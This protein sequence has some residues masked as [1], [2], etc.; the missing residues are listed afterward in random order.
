MCINCIRS[1]S[2]SLLEF[3]CVCNIKS[4]HYNS[5]KQLLCLVD[6]YKKNKIN[7]TT[8][9]NNSTSIE[10]N[11]KEKN[12]Q[13]LKHNNSYYFGICKEPNC[14]NVPVCHECILEPD[15]WGHKISKLSCQDVKTTFIP[16]LHK[17]KNHLQ[18]LIDSVKKRSSHLEKELD[19]CK[20]HLS[21][22]K[23]KIKQSFKEVRQY[24]DEMESDVYEQLESHTK[25]EMNKIKIIQ[26]KLSD[27][28]LKLSKFQEFYQSY[29]SLKSPKEISIVGEEIERKELE[30]PDIETIKFEICKQISNIRNNFLDEKL[31]IN[32]KCDLYSFDKREYTLPLEKIQKIGP[33][34]EIKKYSSFTERSTIPQTLSNISS[35]NQFG[36]SSPQTPL[37]QSSFFGPATTPTSLFGQPTTPTSSLFGQVTTPTTSLF[38]QPTTPTT[39]LFQ[40]TTIPSSTTSSLFGVPSTTTGLFGTT[41]TPTSS[42]FGQVTTP[43]SSLFQSTTIPSSTTSSLFGVPSTTTG[44]FGTTTT[45]TSSFSS[46]NSN[47]FGFAFNEAV[48][49]AITSKEEYQSKSFEELRLL[50]IQKKIKDGLQTH[51]EKNFGSL[52]IS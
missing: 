31:E 37:S 42:L 29:Q 6:L 46:Q 48:I 24:L 21:K 13:C 45:P 32:Y 34:C 47:S 5:N 25:S 28:D 17:A 19:L 7:N 4:T 18:D 50:D 11:N 44:I 9:K 43:T 51:N 20:K 10:N 41:T 3:T 26:D 49:V 30:E 36:F 39:S 15:H 14:N 12:H 22:E 27:E 8:T 23:E 16:Q 52:S 33:L 38:G 35:S 40:S 2:S 1:S